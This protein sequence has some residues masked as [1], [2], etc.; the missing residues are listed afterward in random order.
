MARLLHAVLAAGL[1]LIST[2]GRSPSP[3]TTTL[4]AEPVVVTT[5]IASEAQKIPSGGAPSADASVGR[6]TSMQQLTEV[7]LMYLPRGFHAVDGAY[8]VIF[9]FHGAPGAIEAAVEANHINAAVL[10]VNLGIGSGPYEDRYRDAKA[11]D[12]VL[13]VI[14]RVISKNGISD[15]HVGRIAL[16]AWSAGYGAVVHALSWSRIAERVDAVLLADGMHAAFKTGRG[17][18]VDDLRMAPFLSWAKRAEAGERLMAVTHSSIETY[19]YASTTETSAY[20]LSHLGLEAHRAT[21]ATS[22]PAMSMLSRADD[23]DLHVMAF[24]G[25]NTDAHA[26]HLLALGDTLYPLLAARWKR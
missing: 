23:H 2:G 5:P 4:A 26:D 6:A 24:A 3:E 9:H 1:S 11:L 21:L 8:D 22:R 25:N 16:S 20:L 18:E 17:H 10:I 15:A 13:P 19:G 7:G 14:D 12:R